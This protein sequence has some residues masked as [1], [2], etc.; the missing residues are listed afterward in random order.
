MITN[1]TVDHG[2]CYL[3]YCDI[4]TYKRNREG[5][6]L[7]KQSSADIVVQTESEVVP[8]GTQAVRK[9]TGLLRVVDGI[10]EEIDKPVKGELVH[11]VQGC[12]V[13]QG[14]EEDGG[15]DGNRA[16]TKTSGVDLGGIQRYR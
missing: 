13:S 3:S 14:E 11:G 8:Q 9:L 15:S 5:S 10:G 1:A 16:V 12:Q 2:Q 7:F 6:Y 4:S